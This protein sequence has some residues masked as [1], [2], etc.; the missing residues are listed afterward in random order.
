MITRT[1]S[2][3]HGF[4]ENYSFEK[5]FSCECDSCGMSGL[6]GQLAGALTGGA[7]PVVL[8][9]VTFTDLET[10]E[11]IPFG[12]KQMLAVHK[13]PGGMRVIDSMGRDDMDIGWSGIL[14]GPLATPRALQIDQLRIQGLPIT[15]TWD[16][17][18]WTVVVSDFVADYVHRNWIHTS[19]SALCRWITRQ[20]WCREGVLSACYRK[21]CKAILLLPRR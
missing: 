5:S 2:F 11:K 13:L 16:V 1:I 9:P 18:S 6:L 3:A 19:S 21:V 14:E 15:L 4:V 10:P 12:G 17:L 20:L 7:P 8:G